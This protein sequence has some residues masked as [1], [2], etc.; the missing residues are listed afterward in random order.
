MRAVP[1][2]RDRKRALVS[3]LFLTM[4]IAGGL[5]ACGGGSPS[6]N[7]LTG[8][9][10][11]G[12]GG[13]TP[14]ANCTPP[15]AIT[16]T[17]TTPSVVGKTAPAQFIGLHVGSNNLLSQVSIPYGTLRL[18]DTGT[19]WSEINTAPGV[20]DFSSIDAFTGS[21]SLPAG[22]DFIYNLART[23]TWASSDA[24]DTTCDYDTISG[25]PGQCWPPS[26]LNSDG[27]GADA[28]WIN[29][30]TAVAQHNNSM[31]DPIKYYEIWNE[32]NIQLF[33]RGSAAQL[34]RMEQDARCVV[35]GP[36][37]GFSC[38]NPNSVF[39][40]G[41]GL[42]P[43]AKIVSPSPVGAA[44]TLDSVQ[45][46]LTTYFGTTVNGVNGG[47]FSDVIGFHG[48]VGTQSSSDPCPTAE[49][50]ITVMNDLNGAVAGNPAE[51][52][53]NL[54]NKPWFDTEDGWSKAIDEGFTDPDRQAGFI[55]RYNLLQFSLGV[56][57]SYFYRWDSPTSDSALWVSPSG[58][59]E[60]PGTAYGE[61]YNW[62]VGATL[63]SSCSASGSVY[64]CGFTRP[65]NNY[66]ALA[67]WDA[68]QDCLSG[69]CT[70]SNFTV[71]AGYA[72]SRDLTGQETPISGGTVAIGARPI[73]LETVTLP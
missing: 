55:A 7:V 8:G 17:P 32:W 3:K 63:S 29:W 28:D 9:G 59:I 1:S 35:E 51:S 19:G 31:G 5:T 22:T 69:I 44:S 62:M 23:P 58:P 71:P 56:D 39:P 37:T 57:R 6:S 45:T 40:S 54:V 43:G 66:R 4:A 53:V 13:G 33:W 65:Q 15:A 60:E 21:G 11:G 48:Y 12:G 10:G 41:T 46:N 25:G 68:S 42:D 38:N 2:P 47:I 72:I 70:T 24:T 27:S 49:N 50:V 34:V 30:V 16:T 52:Q 20:F 73:L 36:P 18:W 26:D 14:A 64:T 67:V 61:V